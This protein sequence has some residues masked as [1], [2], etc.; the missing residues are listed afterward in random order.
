MTTRQIPFTIERWKEGLKPVTKGKK[1]VKQLVY[2]EDLDDD[3]ALA[4]VIDSTLMHW[5][6]D[7][8]SPWND[9]YLLMLVEEVREPREWICVVEQDGHLS[10]YPAHECIPTTVTIK[11]REVIGDYEREEKKT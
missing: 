4:G 7:G 9:D 10:G 11:V 3:C 5:T 6:L 1:E 8:R 2:F